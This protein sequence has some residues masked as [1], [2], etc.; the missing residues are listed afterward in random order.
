MTR[1]LQIYRLKQGWTLRQ[2][3]E[4]TGLSISTLWRI[5]TGKMKP[6]ARARIALAARLPGAT[7]QLAD[8]LGKP[9]KNKRA[10]Q[11]RK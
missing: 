4:L 10:A 3:S 1:E 8:L 2:M 5:E 11:V 7:E 9:A 6:S